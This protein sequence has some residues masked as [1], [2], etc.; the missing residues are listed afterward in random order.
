M[1]YV[2]TASSAAYLQKPADLDRYRAIF[3]QILN[4]TIPLQEYSS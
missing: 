3:R 1:V 4:I 2:E